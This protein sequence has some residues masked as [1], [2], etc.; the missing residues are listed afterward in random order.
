MLFRS[1]RT[2]PGSIRNTYGYPIVVVWGH[3]RGFLT[4]VPKFRARFWA[5]GSLKSPY[6]GES[7]KTHDIIFFYFVEQHQG[8]LLVCLVCSGDVL[9]VLWNHLKYHILFDFWGK[10]VTIFIFRAFNGF[11]LEKY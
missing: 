4:G 8:F 9:N 1:P 2:R 3:L 11:P 7:L 5:W 6:T 10:K